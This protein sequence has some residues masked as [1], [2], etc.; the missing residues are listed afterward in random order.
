METIEAQVRAELSKITTFPES[1]E[2]EVTFAKAAASRCIKRMRPSD[3]CR[4]W[5]EMARRELEELKSR[6]KAFSPYEPGGVT[7]G[8][9]SCGGAAVFNSTMAKMLA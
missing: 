9:F 7:H 4:D 3:K 1:I 2:E 5:A 6:V 8:I